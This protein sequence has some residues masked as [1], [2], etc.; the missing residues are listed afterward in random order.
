MASRLFV[1]Y[2]VY[3]KPHHTTIFTLTECKL[4]DIIEVFAEY[5]AIDAVHIQEGTV[6]STA[7]VAFKNPKAAT[8]ALAA[9][10]KSVKGSTILVTKKQVSG[11][12]TAAKAQKEKTT[13]TA[14]SRERSVYVKF[15]KRGT[16][17]EQLKE[18]FASCG[19]VEQVK[20][21][22][23]NSITFAFV[24]FSDKAVV[25]TALKLHNSLL[26]GNTIGVFES[27]VDAANQMSKRDP[28]LTVML[29]NTQNL[30][31]VEG[32]K[33]QS[34][35]AKCGEIESM[36]VVCRKTALA[37][38]TFKNKE[39]VEKAFKLSGKT[40][41]DINLEVVAYNPDKQK[42]SIFI[43]NIA[44]GKKKRNNMKYILIC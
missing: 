17:E 37:F 30:E 3:L 20:V 34:I 43:I 38:I 8:K 2:C 29:K 1:V 40:V 36:D 44:K 26:N 41:N 14:E 25:Q 13:A 39:A 27:S 32:D 7:N 5:G 11:K 16:T 22:L 31:G 19:E 33:L 6:D 21:I 15:L 12:K 23:K 35:F 42:T 18:H 9:N 24:T 4:V 10:K 28:E